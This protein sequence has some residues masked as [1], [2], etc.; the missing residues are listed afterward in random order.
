MGQDFARNPPRFSYD[1]L[2]LHGKVK[3][4]E[5]ENRKLKDTITHL[6]DV[7]KNKD[8]TIAAIKATIKLLQKGVGD[9]SL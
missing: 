6:R 4:V 8:E 9:D 1:D 3:V 5:D 7:I 2:P